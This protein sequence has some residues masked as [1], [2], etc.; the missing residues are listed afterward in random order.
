MHPKWCSLSRLGL[1]SNP[2]TKFCEVVAVIYYRKLRPPILDYTELNYT[3]NKRASLAHRINTHLTHI[4]GNRELLTGNSVGNV[5]GF[6]ER[7]KLT[8]FLRRGSPTPE[9]HR[10]ILTKNGKQFVPHC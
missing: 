5:R 3:E 1:N 6:E 2:S 10:E 9:D 4:K 8:A 7:P